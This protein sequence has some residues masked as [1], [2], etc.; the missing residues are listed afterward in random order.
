MRGSR[1]KFFHPAAWGAHE[2]LCAGL[3]TSTARDD[4]GYRSIRAVWQSASMEI[5]ET[6]T[7]LEFLR[8]GVDLLTQLIGE[9]ADKRPR[10]RYAVVGVYC[11]FGDPLCGLLEVIE[12]AGDIEEFFKDIHR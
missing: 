10:L 12:T 6:L 4:A 7:L 1:R 8:Q 3:G 5:F 11:L 9:Y 2:V